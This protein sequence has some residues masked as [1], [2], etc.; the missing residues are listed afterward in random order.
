MLWFTD[1]RKRFSF[2]R[3]FAEAR[4]LPFP[5]VFGCWYGNSIYLSVTDMFSN[6]RTCS[7]F[8]SFIFNASTDQTLNPSIYPTRR[9]IYQCL[10]R[11]DAQSH[12]D[13]IPNLSIYWL[14]V[15]LSRCMCLG[16][17]RDTSTPAWDIVWKCKTWACWQYSTQFNASFGPTTCERHI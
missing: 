5:S 11:P 3:V 10:Y 8:L 9:S 1:I 7:C 6:F 4:R 14:S 16:I 12:T 17:S 2:S 15:Y 13:W